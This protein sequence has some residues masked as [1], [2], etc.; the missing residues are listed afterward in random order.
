MINRFPSLIIHVLEFRVSLDLIEKYYK[1]F[2]SL[3]ESINEKFKSNNDHLSFINFLWLTYPYN[4]PISQQILSLLLTKNYYFRFVKGEDKIFLCSSSILWKYELLSGCIAEFKRLI[5]IKKIFKNLNTFLQ[6]H[7]LL[8]LTVALFVQNKTFSKNLIH[9]DE[10]INQ[11]LYEIC[12]F[13]LNEY[14][15]SSY[16][17][18]LKIDNVFFMLFKK[19]HTR[20]VKTSILKKKTSPFEKKDMQYY[21]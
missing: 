1:S 16:L 17:P 11:E 13:I 8:L 4:G 7:S 9:L 10:K 12:I 15:E 2:P 19:V 18:F 14:N 21:K 5:E 3:F 20:I 6:F